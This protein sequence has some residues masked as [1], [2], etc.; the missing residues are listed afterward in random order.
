MMQCS[1]EDGRKGFRQAVTGPPAP[2][3]WAQ[4]Y[5]ECHE[6]MRRYLAQRVRCPHDV[7][8]LMQDVF[9]SLITR[10]GHLQHPEIY[11]YTVVRNR[12]CAYWRRKAAVT[13]GAV[14]SYS[15]D[16]PVNG[17]LYDCESDPLNQLAKLEKRRIVAS[18]IE[19]LSPCQA[20]AL[21]LRFIEGLQPRQAALRAG[22]SRETFKKRLT[23]A[24]RALTQKLMQSWQIGSSVAH[25]DDRTQGYD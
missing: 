11:A 7:D 13:E 17:S 12:L 5:E 10:G 8:D 18:T 6:R 14:S 15:S 4:L 22:C 3:D 1:K 20:E 16:L 25:A 9:T 24:R 23:Y 19:R 2:T 21:R